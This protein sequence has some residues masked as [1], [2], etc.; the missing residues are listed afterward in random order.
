[1]IEHLR[2]KWLK[3]RLFKSRRMF[4]CN[5]RILKNMAKI[6]GVKHGA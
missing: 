4:E 6:M 2:D 1:M 5:Y 3:L